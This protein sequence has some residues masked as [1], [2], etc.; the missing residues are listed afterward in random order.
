MIKLLKYFN[1]NIIIYSH[2]ILTFFLEIVDNIINMIGSK[3]NK[4]RKSENNE[5]EN[6]EST[7]TMRKTESY[8]KFD[9]VDISTI[10]SKIQS[11]ISKNIKKIYNRCKTCSNVLIIKNQYTYHAYDNIYCKGCW[12]QEKIKRP[13]G[14]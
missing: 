13:K 1:N 4:K 8:D 6:N 14:D 11:H 3:I 10:Q 9:F 12:E 7:K 5:S 2:L